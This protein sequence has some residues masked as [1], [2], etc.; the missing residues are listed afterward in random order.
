VGLVVDVKADEIRFIHAS[1]SRGVIVSSLRE[2]YW[3]DAFV[4]ATRVF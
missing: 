1:T 4:R 2:G 3:N